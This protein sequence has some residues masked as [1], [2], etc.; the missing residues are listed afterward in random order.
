MPGG[1]ALTV[2]GRDASSE[3]AIIGDAGR[4]NG[5]DRLDSFVG[6]GPIF[7]RFRGDGGS[8]FLTAVVVDELGAGKA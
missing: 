5:D 7:C 2:K 6:A 8:S 4:A 1:R 3:L